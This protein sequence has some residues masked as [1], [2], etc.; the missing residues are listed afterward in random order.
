MQDSGDP[1]D[2]VETCTDDLA[3]AKINGTK[4]VSICNGCSLRY[5]QDH[6]CMLPQSLVINC[7]VGGKWN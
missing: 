7:A 4:Q 5:R 3:I 1:N 6:L 2:L